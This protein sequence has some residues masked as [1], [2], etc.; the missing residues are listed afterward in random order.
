MTDDDKPV[1][2]IISTPQ[3]D[4]EASKTTVPESRV[5][6]NAWV[7]EGDII[8]VDMDLARD[9]ARDKIRQERAP[10]LADL[11]T[12]YLRLSETGAAPTDIIAAKQ[13]LRDA[14]QDSRLDAAQDPAS[15]E[16]A[17]SV[18]IDEMKDAV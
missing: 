11:D 6:R 17:M 15:L 12:Q 7:L 14:P 1:P 13:K 3:G 18:I 5:F 8:I 9:V 16:E 2:T 10:L 4:I